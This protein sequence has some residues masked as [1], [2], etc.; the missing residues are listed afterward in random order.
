MGQ[1]QLVTTAISSNLL[2][3]FSYKIQPW[4]VRF[5]C[6]FAIVSSPKISLYFHRKEL[7]VAPTPRVCFIYPVK[8]YHT[9]IV[10]R[11]VC[12]YS[13]ALY[14]P[15]MLAVTGLLINGKP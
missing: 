5:C 11:L 1:G 3:I 10:T 2:D 9:L 15:P 14:L 12:R 13:L 4:C 7:L 6:N 8:F